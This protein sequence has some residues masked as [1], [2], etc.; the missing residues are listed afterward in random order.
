MADPD[1]KD[2]ATLEEERLTRSLT[3]SK[4][5]GR[6]AFAAAHASPPKKA[7]TPGFNT[8]PAHGNG[9][10]TGPISPREKADA[11]SPGGAYTVGARGPK[12][13]KDQHHSGPLPEWKRVQLEREEAEKKR[14]EEEERRK[15][16]YSDQIVHSASSGFSNIDTTSAMSGGNFVDP[17][18]KRPSESP[19]KPS[20]DVVTPGKAMFDDKDAE[21]DLRKEE[22][23][24]NRRTG[25]APIKKKSVMRH[26]ESSL[27]GNAEKD[28]HLAL[29][30]RQQKV[31]I[32]LVDSVSGDAIQELPFFANAGRLPML[33]VEGALKIKNVVWKETKQALSA[34][35]DG[36]STI[37]VGSRNVIEVIADRQ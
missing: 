32:V 14:I 30:P 25:N 33:A 16:M 35:P 7:S 6:N 5:H 1:R 24:L 23:Y 21:E 27:T 26:P 15:K 28:A 20:E 10:G 2:E 22:E 29:N 12:I 17:L 8:M 34:G 4:L 3:N 31:L 13:V 18:A 19:I 37:S 9:H 36:F 11:G